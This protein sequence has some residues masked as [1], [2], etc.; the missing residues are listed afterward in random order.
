MAVIF[1]VRPVRAHGH[2]P[3]ILDVGQFAARSPRIV[4]MSEGMTRGTTGFAQF[5][6]VPQPRHDSQITF[7][8]EEKVVAYYGGGYLY[9]TAKRAEPVL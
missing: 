1:C 9:A 8:E 6:D 5:A 3:S 4:S 2:S 7:L